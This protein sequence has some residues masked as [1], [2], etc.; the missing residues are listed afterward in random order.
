M[1]FQI[2]RYYQSGAGRVIHI[3]AEIHTFFHGT[4][5]L[6][7]EPTGNLI[8]VGSD[9]EA[10]RNWKE[11]SGWPRHCYTV[12]N[13]DDPVESYAVKTDNEVTP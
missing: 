2:G 10:A 12:N 11:V 5:L 9:E 3:L 8:P 13:I 7:E 4:C 6:A 1:K